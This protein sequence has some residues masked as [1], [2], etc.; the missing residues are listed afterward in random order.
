MELVYD[1]EIRIYLN[2][3]VLPR[4]F[5][6]RHWVWAQ[7]DKEAMRLVSNPEF[8]PTATVVI[9]NMRGGSS[10]KR[11]VSEVSEGKSAGAATVVSYRSERVVIRAE[12]SDEA[13]LL[14]SDAWYPGWKCT[15]DGAEVPVFAADYLFRGVPLAKGAHEVVFSYK[16]TSFAWGLRLSLLSAAC[17]L[18]SLIWIRMHHG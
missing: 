3:T 5:L 13:I 17:W 7:D 9:Q 12:A 8:D 10:P 18:L 6:V 16:P 1:K 11:I 15:V 2:K 14:L 4:A